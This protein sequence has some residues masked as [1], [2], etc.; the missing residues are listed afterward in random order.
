MCAACESPG[1]YYK[2]GRCESCKIESLQLKP[3]TILVLGLGGGVFVLLAFVN[4]VVRF[5]G[6]VIREKLRVLRKELIRKKHAK[7]RKHAQRQQA[8][9]RKMRYQRRKGVTAVSSRAL[10]SFHATTL[11]SAHRLVS[12]AKRSGKRSAE[13]VRILL[14]FAKSINNLYGTLSYCLW[15][16]TAMK[17]VLALMAVMSFDLVE[18]ARMPCYVVD[19]NYFDKLRTAALGPIV[20]TATLIFIGVAW[21][22]ANRV[23]EGL[24]NSKKDVEETA[25]ATER[26]REDRR[27]RKIRRGRG[28]FRAGVIAAAPFLLQVVDLLFPTTARTLLEY[29]T[30]R[31]LD[32]AGWYL[33]ADCTLCLLLSCRH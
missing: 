28:V 3:G 6:P 18:Q 31:N 20:M 19:F 33:E 27:W 10:Y 12:Q 30:C 13:S 4:V 24:L 9:R 29:F 1:W 14:N 8:K 16:P 17:P 5:K 2:D 21:T 26:Q 25:G 22:G 11:R 23:F 32:E 7:S 15:W